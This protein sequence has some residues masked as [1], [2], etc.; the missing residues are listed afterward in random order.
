MVPPG[1][2]P[3]RDRGAGPHVSTPRRRSRTRSSLVL[4][5]LGDVTARSSFGLVV[6]GAVAVWLVVGA[7]Q[8][9]P[10]W[11]VNGF[12]VAGTAITLV[13]V[14]AIQHT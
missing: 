6:F 1:A 4:H 13:M 10:L 9:F 2:R 3:A 7:T 5:R 8:G 14:F 11:W 12:E